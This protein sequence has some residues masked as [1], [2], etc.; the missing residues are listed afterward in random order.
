MRTA[1]A[2]LISLLMMSIFP[3]VI[4]AASDQSGSAFSFSFDGI[5][6]KPMPLSAYQGKVLLVVN[7]ASFCGFTQQYEG[8]QAL[9]QKY[10][11]QGLVVIGV[12][13]NDFG[14]QEP[15]S[16]GE[17]ANFCKGAFGVTFPLTAKTVVIGEAAHAFYKWAKEALGGKGTPGWNFH[18]YLVGRSG[19]LVA[20][21]PSQVPPD[22]GDIV[23]AIE[24]ELA[25]P[26]PA[27]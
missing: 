22:H 9:S 2:K 18:K 3:T 12:P 5:D 6:G 17:I 20:A 26:V 10:E 13:S 7:T 11:G 1:V 19:R 21:F 8:L 23:A 25:V 14:Q 24:R 27:L 16:E 4:A 15:K